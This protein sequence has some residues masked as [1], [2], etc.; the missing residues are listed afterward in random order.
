M[1]CGVALVL[2]LAAPCMAAPSKRGAG[3]NSVISDHDPAVSIRLPASAHYLGTDRFLLHDS[4]M[5]DFDDCEL[6][7]FADTGYGRI[8][9]KLYWVQFES[10][11]PSHP[12]LHH[13]YDSPRHATLGGLDFYV[14]T[15]ISA[16]DSGQTPGS[17][18]EHFNA[19]LHKRGVERPDMAWVRLVH[20]TDAS[21]RKELMI[22]YGEAVPGGMTAKSPAWPAFEQLLIQRAEKAV[23]I[24]PAG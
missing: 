4:K 7:A 13:Q 20:L 10:Y 5:G 6:F 22:I 19:L 23:A 17:D 24:Q 3:P 12:G 21:R 14:D 18:G 9:K 11:L 16:A 15:W 2:M 1:R 8:A